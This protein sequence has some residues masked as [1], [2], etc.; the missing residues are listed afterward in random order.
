MA[1]KILRIG[2]SA[3]L[4]LLPAF[5]L[6]ALAHPLN[7]T[8]LAKEFNHPLLGLDHLLDEPFLYITAVII[9]ALSIGIT[10]FIM[11][12]KRNTITKKTTEIAARPELN[13]TVYE[14]ILDSMKIE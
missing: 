8:G 9:L 14:K 12:R 7:G 11:K 2:T 4:A 3:F 6:T 10:G 5:S 1:T 13:P